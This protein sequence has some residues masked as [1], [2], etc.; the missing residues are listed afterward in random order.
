MFHFRNYCEHFSSASYFTCAL[1]SVCWVSFW[2][3][4]VWYVLLNAQT[5]GFS[6][7]RG[8]G[9]EWYTGAWHKTQAALRFTKGKSVSILVQSD[10]CSTA[11][12][13]PYMW[14]HWT[15]RS[16]KHAEQQR[17]HLWNVCIL[18]IWVHHF[19]CFRFSRDC[20]ENSATPLP[21]RQ[22]RT[23][24]SAVTGAILTGFLWLSSVPPLKCRRVPQIRLKT[25]PSISLQFIIH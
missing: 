5:R 10:I 19:H 18:L 1:N 3:V 9:Q 8:G 12:W 21:P 25:L 17:V 11:V 14:H 7:Q 16:M 15:S 13:V 20:Y 4:W 22:P 23:V 2:F 24:I 6:S